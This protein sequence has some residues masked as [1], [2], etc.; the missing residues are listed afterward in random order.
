MFLSKDLVARLGM[1]LGDRDAGPVFVGVS[2]R[3]LGRRQAQ[4]RLGAWF[5]AAGIRRA[6]VH[7]LR[8]SFAASLYRRTGD[9][10]L[11]KEALGH[12]SIS[13]TLV[14]ARAEAGRVRSAVTSL[15]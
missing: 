6:K 3:R 14:Y 13:S 11:V 1:F 5:E 9:V 15:L 8:H 4:R 12:R 2:G 7:S 10:L